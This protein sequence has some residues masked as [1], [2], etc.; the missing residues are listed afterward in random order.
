[1]TIG[2]YVIKNKINNKMYIGQSI[3]IESRWKEHINHLNSHNH[4]NKHLNCSWNKYHQNNF[5]FIIIAKCKTSELDFLERLFI[6]LYKTTNPK[7]G[8]NKTNGGKDING[9]NNPNYERDCSGKNNSFY[10]KKHSQKSKKLMR[11]AK[12][13]KKLTKQHKKSI[14]DSLTNRIRSDEECR[15]ISKGQNSTGYYR[16]SKKKAKSTKQGYSY[17][18]SWRENGKRRFI[19]S[20]S[21]KKLEQKV[22]ERNLPWEKI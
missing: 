6:K 11:D 4:N 18:Y 17:S 19:S 7:Y 8:Y 15:A 16:V 2:I 5:D 9:E 21:L 14:S 3:H 10:G 20:V 12:L 13:G 22:K 1:M